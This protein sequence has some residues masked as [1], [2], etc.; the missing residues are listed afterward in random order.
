MA[1]GLAA[2]V[3]RATIEKSLMTKRFL[4][5]SFGAAALLLFSA[6]ALAHNSIAARYV[7]PDARFEWRV[8]N[9]RIHKSTNPD[10]I[11]YKRGWFVGGGLGSSEASPE[12]SSGGFYVK[13]DRDWGYKIFA[14]LRAL[15]HW[16]GEISY[17]NTGKAGLGNVNPAIEASF[18]DAT[19]QYHIPTISGS[20]HVFGPQRDIDVFGRVGLS[21]IINTVSD[22]RIPYEKQTP[23]QL[24]LGVGLQWRFDDLWFARAEYDSFDND[25]SMISLSLGRYFA[26][27]NEHREIPM[28]V[29]I[30]EKTCAQFN[31]VLEFVSFEVDSDQLTET[32]KPSLI[33]L[34]E[35]LIENPV[36]QV[37]IQAHTDSSGTE[38]YNLEL[39]NRRANTIKTFLEEQGVAPSRLIATGFGESTPRATNDTEEGRAKN[40]R[41]EFKVINSQI[42]E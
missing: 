9:P 7:V 39:S 5:A 19:I 27:H 14:G 10:L 23:L 29:V 21:S 22:D 3:V 1:A 32:S 36:V 13:D 18:S 6:N 30:P 26:P 20:Y 40:R 37:E 28:P 42:C 41:V 12:G 11:Q 33:E 4:A 34:A 8:Y 35:S 17:V 31:S 15:P 38:E 16:S 2:F 25:A 24:N